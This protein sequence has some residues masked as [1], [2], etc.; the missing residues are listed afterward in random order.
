M[1]I[2]KHKKRDS[3]SFKFMAAA[4]ALLAQDTG[5]QGFNKMSRTVGGHAVETRQEE[6]VQKEQNP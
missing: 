6:V 1:S 4:A 2:E 5:E 3:F